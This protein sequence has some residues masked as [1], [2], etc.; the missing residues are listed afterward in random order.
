MRFSIHITTLLWGAALLALPPG[1]AQA[2]QVQISQDVGA[3]L[4]IEPNDIAQAGVPTQLWFALTRAGGTVIPLADCDCRLDVYD[5]QGAPVATPELTPTSAEGYEAIPSATVT[6]PAVG[7]YDL[8]LSG[9]PQSSVDFAEFELSF[10]VTVAR[11]A[12]QANQTAT[13]QPAT[14]EPSVPPSVESGPDVANTALGKPVPETES[15]VA[16]SNQWNRIALW[17]G[18]IVVLGLIVAVFSGRRS[19]GGK[20]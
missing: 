13:D 18:A 4:H 15:T 8:V 12:R 5:S 9:Q 3:T 14:S 19:P 11:A 16:A 20:V 10:E 7:T 17:G 1:T 2:H 6:L